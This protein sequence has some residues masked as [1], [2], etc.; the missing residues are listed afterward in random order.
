MSNDLQIIYVTFSSIIVF[1]EDINCVTNIKLS[2]KKSR[3]QLSPENAEPSAPRQTCI[4]PS[5]V[6]HL[7]QCEGSLLEMP[8]CVA[9]DV[10]VSSALWL[11]GPRRGA[12]LS[13]HQFHKLHFKVCEAFAAI[14]L[15]TRGGAGVFWCEYLAPDLVPTRVKVWPAEISGSRDLGL[16]N[17]NLKTGMNIFW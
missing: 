2:A 3:A 15:L 17:S 7:T 4:W 9:D 8:T 16:K 5:F 11:P 13:P 14:W 6:Q 12:T 10:C 1:A